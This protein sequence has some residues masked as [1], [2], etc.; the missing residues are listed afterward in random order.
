MYQRRE[1]GNLGQVYHK[2]LDSEV[3]NERGVKVRQHSESRKIVNN[4][5]TKLSYFL[6]NYKVHEDTDC[7]SS[8][9]LYRREVILGD[10]PSQNL[11]EEFSL[12]GLL[13]CNIIAMTHNDY[14]TRSNSRM[15]CTVLLHGP[16]LG[17]GMFGINKF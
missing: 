16:I 9:F 2:E 3:E 17:K 14:L 13:N 12:P 5:S 11:V 6:Y 8:I 4:T 10:A 1:E 15:F 7:L